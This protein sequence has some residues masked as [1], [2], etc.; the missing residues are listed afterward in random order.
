M[1]IRNYI[2][3]FFL[4]RWLFSKLDKS[5]KVQESNCADT[6]IDSLGI[7]EAASTTFLNEAPHSP[8][9]FASPEKVDELDDLDIFMSN[10]Q[11]TKYGNS[12]YVFGRYSDIDSGSQYGWNDDYDQSFNDLHDEQ[13]D[14]DMMDDF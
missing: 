8:K 6:I 5:N 2:G 7:D 12:D 1:K 9:E 4:F 13:D 3:E 14:Y 11:H 10:N